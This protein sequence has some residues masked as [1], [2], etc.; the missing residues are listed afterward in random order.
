MSVRA[1]FQDAGLLM[2]SRD[3]WDCR[4]IAELS[5]HASP[6]WERKPHFLPRI[7][8]Y[9]TSLNGWYPFALFLD[10]LAGG[11]NGAISCKVDAGDSELVREATPSI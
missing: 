11:V 2:G 7:L 8:N 4:G 1:L 6:R 5:N 9:W 3:D 10:D